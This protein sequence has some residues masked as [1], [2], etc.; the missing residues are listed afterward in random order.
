M[1]PTEYLQLSCHHV[2]M[3]GIF[4][5][6]AHY[7]ISLN[8]SHTSAAGKAPEEFTGAARLGL[9]QTSPTGLAWKNTG[10]PRRSTI[11]PGIK[12]KRK[13]SENGSEPQALSPG[14]DAAALPAGQRCVTGTAT[15]QPRLRERGLRP[16]EILVSVKNR[17]VTRLHR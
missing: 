9:H 11:K 7:I 17:V 2:Q 14:R 6:A 3:Y 5:I 10:T 16:T 1:G 4:T 12:G 13:S 15:P 8:W